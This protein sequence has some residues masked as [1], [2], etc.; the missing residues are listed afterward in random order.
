MDEQAPEFLHTEGGAKLAYHLTR[1]TGPTVV[2]LSGFAS[3]MGGSKAVHLQRWC[4]ARGQAYLRLDYQGHGESSGN[5]EDGAVGVWAEDALAVIEAVVEGPLVLVGSSMGAWI[6]L[7]V[8]RRLGDRVHG[9]VGVAS[10]PDFTEELIHAQLTGE[11]KQR[12]HAAGRVERASDYD[13]GPNVFTI[14][15]L[16]DGRRH[17]VLGEVIPIECPVRLIHG[18]QDGD[19]PWSISLRLCER[20]ESEDVQLTLV[21]SGEHRLSEPSELDL[22]TGVVDDLLT[23]VR[24]R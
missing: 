17:Q 18:L 5:F 22:L 12:L 8:A 3:H 14:G 16:E 6:M 20:L 23:T 9:L 10:A 21:K 7:L 11:E 19:V 15:M 1:G 2:F 24:A 4:E 13:Q